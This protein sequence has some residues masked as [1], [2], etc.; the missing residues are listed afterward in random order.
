L[1]ATVEEKVHLLKDEMRRGEVVLFPGNKDQAK[2]RRKL[3]IDLLMRKLKE[4]NERKE[5]KEDKL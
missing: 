2:G 1:E 3:Q 5:N 4:L